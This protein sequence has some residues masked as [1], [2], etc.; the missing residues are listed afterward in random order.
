MEIPW[1]QICLGCFLHRVNI[2]AQRPTIHHLD[3]LDPKA[4]AKKLHL[5][6]VEK[7]VDRSSNLS[8]FALKVQKSREKKENMMS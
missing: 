5:P 7:E 3:Y 4:I 1:S 8:Y 6:K 2:V